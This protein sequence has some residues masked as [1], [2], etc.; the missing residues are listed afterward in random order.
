MYNNFKYGSMVQSE[1]F[2]KIFKRLKISEFIKIKFLYNI[3]INL[4][5]NKF[6]HLY[7]FI[8]REKMNAKFNELTQ[9]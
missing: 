7:E 1:Y 3:K 9:G 5:F 4:Y 8:D 6:C 2:L